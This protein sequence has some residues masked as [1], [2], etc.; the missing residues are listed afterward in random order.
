MHI[1]VFIS[2]LNNYKYTIMDKKV[3]LSRLLLLCVVLL[4]MGNSMVH[5]QNQSFQTDTV[6]HQ[7]FGCD[8]YLLPANHTVYYADTVIKI[9]HYIADQ[10]I[11]YMDVLDVY[12]ITIG[13]SYDY[14]DTVTARVCRNKLP[15]AYHGN[16]Y[17]K[18]GSYWVNT[19]T[20]QGCDSLRTL[21]NLVVLEGQRDTTFVSMCNANPVVVNGITFPNPGTFNFPQGVDDDGCPVVQT[22]VITQYPE[23]VDTVDLLLCQNEIPYP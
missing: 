16:F 20:L 2:F 1:F 8:S 7:E 15:Y 21:V 17:T 14:K 11:V 13:H 12:Q 22:Y 23:I 3:I 10:G 9:P 5:A 18:P 6:I 19:P 4:L